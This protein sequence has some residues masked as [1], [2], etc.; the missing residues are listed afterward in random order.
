M[1]L[2]NLYFSQSQQQQNSTALSQLTAN[3]TTPPQLFVYI[4]DPF[5]YF[6]Y[7]NTKLQSKYDEANGKKTSSAQ[8]APQ[9]SKS[10]T[11]G[12][13]SCKTPLNTSLETDDA[14]AKEEKMD[15]DM[16]EASSRNDAPDSST[17]NGPEDENDDS[18]DASNGQEFL[19]SESDLKRLRNLGLFKAYLEMLNN[20]PDLFKYSTQFQILPL[21]L[22]MDLQQQS[23]GK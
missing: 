18:N 5:D 10:S 15:E 3:L 9:A 16:P 17:E 13:N 7:I 22:C 12:P 4:I 21:N 8:N 20:I 1:S 14:K 2:F 23:T 19:F 6:S 11:S